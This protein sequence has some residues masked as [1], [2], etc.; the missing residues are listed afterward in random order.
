M[1]YNK[2]YDE[3]CRERGRKML[4]IITGTDRSNK[5]QTLAG[6][7]KESIKNGRNVLILIPD[8]FSLI[9]DRKLYDILGAKDFNRVSIFGPERLAKR[10]VSEH[11]DATGQYCDENQKL[12]MLQKAC[13]TFSANGN[14]SYFKLSLGKS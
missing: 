9:Y 5:T 1:S 7:V 8:Q 14:F 4:R 6:Y 3:N 13:K 2:V 10:L 11:P 12:I